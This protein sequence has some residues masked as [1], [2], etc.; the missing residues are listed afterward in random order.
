MIFAR[1]ALQRRL[2]ELRPIIGGNAVDDLVAKLNTPDRN[3]LPAIWEVVIL[4]ALAQ[5]GRLENE[6]ALF[7]GRRPDVK[8]ANSQIAFTADITTISDE[9]VDDQNPI[10]ELI[11]VVEAT[12]TELGFPI[13]G[14]DI[15]VEPG[16][17][18]L[19]GGTKRFLKMPERARLA[20]FVRKQIKP[21]MRRQK[22][23]GDSIV[24][25]AI[26]TED[27]DL[28]ITIDPAKGQYNSAAYAAYA[29]PTVKNSNPLYRALD[30]KRSQVRG[31][32]GLA[33]VIVADGNSTAIKAQGRSA[34][35]HSARAIVQDVL[36]QTTSIDFVCLLTVHEERRGVFDHSS[37]NRSLA[38][39]I[40]VAPGDVVPAGLTELF[41]AAIS[42]MPKP[43]M[44][45]INGALR[46]R[47][48]GFGFGFHGGYTMSGR[49]IKVSSRETMEMLAGLFDP[50]KHT[51]PNRWSIGQTG[52]GNHTNPF[53]LRL[54]EGRLPSSIKVIPGDENDPDDYL[55]FE[56]SEPDPAVTPF[57]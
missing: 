48:Q 50:T 4:H 11:R 9:G 54:R 43:V 45:P 44:M 27:I 15:H 18:K 36:R 39:E 7:S 10:S 20:E 21:E 38:A 29:L 46:A 32:D 40:I 16:E 2:D 26:V 35:S 6:V 41:E 53:F 57:K 3:R 14:L 49:R 28:K 37:P 47:E 52:S 1:R 22:Q 33:G 17:K 56:F 12:K 23:A 19:A 34:G 51:D 31:A 25:I 30:S 42:D 24:K 13:G 5:H 8:F 55:E